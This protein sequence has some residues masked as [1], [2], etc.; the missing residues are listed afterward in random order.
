MELSNFIRR[1]GLAIMALVLSAVLLPACGGDSKKEASSQSTPISNVLGASTQSDV[2][3]PAERGP[4]AVGVTEMT[5]E[6]T[7]VTTNQPR[8]LRTVIWYPAGEGAKGATLDDTLAAVV[9]AEQARDAGPL[10]IIVWSHGAG[11]DYPYASPYYATHL[12]GHGFV[13]V[14]PQHPGNNKAECQTSTGCTPEGMVD[15]YVNRPADLLFTVAEMSKLN[16]DPSSPFYQMLDMNRIG[17][18]GHSFGG[19][20]TVRMSET[21]VGAPFSA[22]LAMAPC[23]GEATAPADTVTMPLLIMAGDRDTRCVSSKDQAFFD[24]ISNSLPHFLLDFP[25][26]GHSTFGQKCPL[27]LPELACGP[28][29]LA[30]EKAH[31]F[32]NLYATAFFKTYV[33]GETGYSAYLDQ[34]AAADD[35]DVVFTA[36]IP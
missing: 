31:H 18:S 16:D 6:K 7:S 14:A 20:T 32:I 22:A 15:S 17:V 24:G 34:A 27:P 3:D 2:A 12:A 21:P 9:D 8:A 35:P 13:V 19:N 30:I 28:D 29:D 10:P 5:F 36:H 33:A 25:R 26:A 11:G 23:T 1:S 4:Y